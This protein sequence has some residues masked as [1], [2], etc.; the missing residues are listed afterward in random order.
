MPRFRSRHC[1]NAGGKMKSVVFVGGT[2][3]NMISAIEMSEDYTVTVFEL[4]AEIGLPCTAPGHIR[5]LSLLESY[6]D[7]AQMSFLQPYPFAEGYTLR[8]EWVLKH[9]GSIAA[10]KGVNIFTRTRI[11]ECFDSGDSV[12][13]EYIGAGSKD[14]GQ[15]E[16]DY[17]VDDRQWTY[18]APGSK[19]HN[20][21]GLNEIQIPDF[22]EFIHMHGGTSLH[23]DCSNLPHNTYSLPRHEGLTEVW[24]EVP[25]WTPRRGWIETIT[26]FLPKIIENRTIDAQIIE[27]RCVV[28]KINNCD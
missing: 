19:E 1:I 16:C 6:L 15:I 22:G 5:D 9:L 7:S 26:C 14:S 17:L 18:S 28:N 3:S 25:V 21:N 27:G 13:L 10:Y 2:I 24:Q 11:T 8:S 23:S 12:A 20:L 4:N